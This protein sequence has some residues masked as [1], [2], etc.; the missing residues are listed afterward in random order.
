MVQR[1]NVWNALHTTKLPGRAPLHKK[2]Q[3]PIR[4][5]MS[6]VC[7]SPRHKRERSAEQL[8]K[9]R[10]KE[11]RYSVRLAPHYGWGNSRRDRK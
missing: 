7:S 11:L 1:S 10:Q 2:F 3:R 8:Q 9:L 4:F 6:A 5:H